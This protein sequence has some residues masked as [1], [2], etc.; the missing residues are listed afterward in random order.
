MQAVHAPGLQRQRALRC[1]VCLVLGRY[2]NMLKLAPHRPSAEK[3]DNLS[4][5]S[6]HNAT[7]R[8]VASLHGVN[9]KTVRNTAEVAE[10]VIT[11]PS[12]PPVPLLAP[13]TNRLP[14]RVQNLHLFQGIMRP[15][16]NWATCGKRK[17]G[18][19]VHFYSG[20]RSAPPTRFALSP[21]KVVNFSTFSP[22]NR[23]ISCAMIADRKRG[24]F[25][26]FFGA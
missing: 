9:E 18:Q 3:G 19:I 25:D 22:P 26:L 2:Y 12:V 11:V 8:Y 23:C 10:V 7:S 20:N 16:V 4:P 24:K 5:F 1:C 15:R 13:P 14:K 21:E 6:G 17:G